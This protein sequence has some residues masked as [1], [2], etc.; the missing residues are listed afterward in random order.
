MADTPIKAEPLRSDPYPS[1]GASAEARRGD[2]DERLYNAT[3]GYYSIS[4]AIAI[5]GLLWVMSGRRV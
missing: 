1:D 4:I 2:V 3:V 5:G